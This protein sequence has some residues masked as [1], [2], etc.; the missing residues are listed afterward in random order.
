MGDGNTAINAGSINFIPKM[1]RETLLSG[2]KDLLNRLFSPAPYYQR[3]LTFLQYHQRNPRIPLPPP[4]SRDLKAMVKIILALGVKEPG[5]LAFWSY[6]GRL[7]FQHTHQ[8]PL[9]ITLAASGRH[10]RI[11]KD[12]F[13]ATA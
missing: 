6:L 3:V 1:G 2:Y 5:R 4:T 12:Q 10:F 13:C 9:G 7:L 11:L 8:L